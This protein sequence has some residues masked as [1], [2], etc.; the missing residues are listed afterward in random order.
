MIHPTDRQV[1]VLRQVF[2]YITSHGFPPT[3]RELGQSLRIHSTNGV[4]DHLVAL[5]RKGYIVRKAMASRAIA[6]TQE[7]LE[8]LGE[9]GTSHPYA[10]V[11]R[12]SAELSRNGKLLTIRVTDQAIGLLERLKESGLFGDTTEQVCER[13]LYE[14]LRDVLKEIR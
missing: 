13:L 9:E 14:K 12:G 4:N 3:L 5:Q 7:G 1:E 11:V 8:L 10:L 2:D 6:L